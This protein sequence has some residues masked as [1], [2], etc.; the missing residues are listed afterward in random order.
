[1]RNLVPTAMNSCT[2]VLCNVMAYSRGEQLDELWKLHFR[3]KIRQE[4]AS[5]GKTKYFF[6]TW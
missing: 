1:M 2:V 6:L 5:I 3:R 4:H